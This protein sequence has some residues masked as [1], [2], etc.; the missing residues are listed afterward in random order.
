MLNF[1]VHISIADKMLETN[2]S[3]L[4]EQDSSMTPAVQITFLSVIFLLAV[5]GNSL[6]CFV[7]FRFKHLRSVPNVLIVNLSLIDLLNALVNMPLFASFYI[8]R[9]DV[10]TGKWVS[11]VF[12]SLHNFVIYLNV[13]SL[14]VIM[15]DRYGA[16]AYG[17]RY[18]TWKT[19]GKACVV[20][21]LIWA[22][23]TVLLIFLGILRDHV[24]SRYEGLKLMDYRR[25]LYKAVGWQVA[26][27]IFGVPFAII[28]C[29]G[30]LIW[31][32]VKK[33]RRR[34]E[35]LMDGTSCSTQA[36]QMFNTIRQKEIQTAKNVAIIVVAY[37]VCFVPAMA[38]GVCVRRGVDLPWLEY[39]AFVCTYFTSACNPIILSLRA[40]CFKQ[41]IKELVKRKKKNS[42]LPVKLLKVKKIAV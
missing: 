35:K 29:L 26:L 14:L 31:R 9:A 6:V 18:H 28:V 3:T 32:A 24:L 11:Y 4:T 10:F 33:S 36:R 16:I 23:G 13:L 41:V 1:K 25:I 5:A 8:V 15:V 21:G 39:F 22:T 7:V 12:S 40:S 27:V 37:F 2:G 30:V 38:H 20:I 34:I 42:V 19:K 17:L